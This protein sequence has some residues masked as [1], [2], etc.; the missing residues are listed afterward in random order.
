MS[1]KGLKYK[2]LLKVDFERVIKA[3]G[4]FVTYNSKL[5][6][7]TLSPAYVQRTN[8]IKVETSRKI[9]ITTVRRL[10]PNR[11]I[12]NANSRITCQKHSWKSQV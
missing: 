4:S 10:L 2:I 8:A 3:G 9:N 6:A 1:E 5:Q 12:T 7:K 11:K